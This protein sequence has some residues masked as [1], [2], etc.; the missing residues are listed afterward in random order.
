MSM[1][2]G[3]LGPKYEVTEFTT[4][5][6]KPRADCGR[7]ATAG[8]AATGA[9]AGAAASTAAGAGRRLGAGRGTIF[10]PGT[11]M[12][13]PS[14]RRLGLFARPFAGKPMMSEALALN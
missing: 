8:A 10:P 9:G 1:P 6:M 13:E 14:C 2:S 5:Q 12:V 3:W 11:R 4:G 7:L